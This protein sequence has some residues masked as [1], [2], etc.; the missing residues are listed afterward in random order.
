LSERRKTMEVGKELSVLLSGWLCSREE[1]E[2][3]GEDRNDL[4]QI[5]PPLG[6]GLPLYIEVGQVHGGLGEV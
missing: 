3:F 2:L 4:S 6:S 1:L 5:D